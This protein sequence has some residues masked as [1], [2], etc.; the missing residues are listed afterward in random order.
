MKKDYSPTSETKERRILKCQ[1]KLI[2]NS[3]SSVNMIIPPVE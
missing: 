3:W 1:A 2:K